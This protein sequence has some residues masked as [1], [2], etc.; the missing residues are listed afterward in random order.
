MLTKERLRVKQIGDWQVVT[1]ENLHQFVYK[2]LGIKHKLKVNKE[3]V[4]EQ[5]VEK[6]LLYHPL[7][8]AKTFV[9]AD[10]PPFSPKKMPNIIFVDAV[11]GYRGVFQKVPK[12]QG[13]EIDEDCAVRKRIDKDD[14]ERK[15]LKDVQENQINRSYILKKPRHEIVDVYP[16]YLPIWKVAVESELFRETLYLNANTGEHEKYMSERWANGKD[17]L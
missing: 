3:Q 7:W 10:R 6:E 16:A 11:S 8:L 4:R 1:D 9:I 15:Y 5:I 2:N 13:I 17:L 12:M 14:C